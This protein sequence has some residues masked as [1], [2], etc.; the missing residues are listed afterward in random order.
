MVIFI[1]TVLH[2][3]P[4]AIRRV[5]YSNAVV[6]TPIYNRYSSIIVTLLYHLLTIDYRSNDSSQHMGQPSNHLLALQI[7]INYYHI[8]Y[9]PTAT[10]NLNSYGVNR[11]GARV[12]YCSDHHISCSS[13]LSTAR[14]SCP[15]GDSTIVCR[16]RS[17]LYWCYPLVLAWW[18]LSYLPLTFVVIWCCS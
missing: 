16:S 5:G 18:S 1:A 9:K 6:V 10:T 12:H 11:H 13:H 7:I 14:C 2:L 3:W 17:A 15:F 4:W 8:A